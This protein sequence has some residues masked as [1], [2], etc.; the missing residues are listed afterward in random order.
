MR[1]SLSP[2]RERIE[3]AGVGKINDLCRMATKRGA[4]HE[5]LLRW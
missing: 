3:P 1:Y 2:I 5:E 4:F